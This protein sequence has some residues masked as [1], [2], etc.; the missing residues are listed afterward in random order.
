MMI[1]VGM[2][3]D[4]DPETGI[5]T[6]TNFDI[7]TSLEVPEVKSEFDYLYK[8]GINLV[9]SGLIA[10]EKMKEI[11]KSRLIERTG[12][13]PEEFDKWLGY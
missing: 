5:M 11:V 3:Y 7:K 4:R 6:P 9:G 12:K 8:Y 2:L 1:E 13:S 10:E